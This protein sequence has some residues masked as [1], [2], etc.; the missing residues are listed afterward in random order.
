MWF[1]LKYRPIHFHINSISIIR[2]VKQNQ[3]IFFNIEINKQLS[4]SVHSVSQ[5]RFKFRS[6]L[7]LL[8]QIRY[9]FLFRAES[10]IISIDSHI[11]DNIIRKV[12]NVQ[13]EKCWTKNE[14]YS[15]EYFQSRAT[16]RGL[17]LRKYEIRPNICIKVSIYFKY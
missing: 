10:S 6:Q 11:T 2:T 15:C 13:Q 14:A 8:P 4:V 16:R 1:F 7:Q 17:L 12:I 5:I 9:L 3:L